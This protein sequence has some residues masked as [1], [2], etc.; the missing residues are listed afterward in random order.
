M[1]IK[2]CRACASVSTFRSSAFRLR[3]FYRIGR[4]SA[5][6]PFF[7]RLVEHG[8]HHHVDELHGPRAAPFI[9]LY[10][11]QLPQ[12]TGLDILQS[13]LPQGGDDVLVGDLPVLKNRMRS[14]ADFLPIQPGLDELGQRHLK[15]IVGQATIN[16]HQHCLDPI[17]AF[18]LRLGV[19]DQAPA[20]QADL[21][22]P[23]LSVFPVENR[24]FV[25]RSSMSHGYL[26]SLLEADMTD[27]TVRLLRY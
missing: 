21:C 27:S 3:A 8:V 10:P 22:H 17:P 19:L 15:T 12:V 24:P 20:V 9:P 14:P 23:L 1:I 11:V 16:L 5:Q 13:H 25:V 7:Q 4:I 26:L 18:G 2:S 6:D